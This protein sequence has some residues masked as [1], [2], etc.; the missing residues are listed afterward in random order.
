MWLSHMLTNQTSEAWQSQDGCP[1]TGAS[2]FVNI[3]L[4]LVFPFNFI[5]PLFML[6]SCNIVFD[7]CHLPARKILSI[8]RRRNKIAQ[9][10]WHNRSNKEQR[11]TLQALKPKSTFWDSFIATY[12]PHLMCQYLTI[13]AIRNKISHY[14][15]GSQ[16]EK[17]K[18][19]EDSLLL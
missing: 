13:V 2:L 17:N 11:K 8:Q 15:D 19:N 16:G 18:V 14:S 9:I 1:I 7:M 4:K 12:L 10:K 3:Y 6:H 5:F